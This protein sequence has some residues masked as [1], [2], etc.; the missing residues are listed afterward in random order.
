M[1]QKDVYILIIS[2]SATILI[3][4]L[5]LIILFILF[6]RRRETYLQQITQTRIEVQ[7]QTLKNISWEIHD[8]IGQILSTIS[9]YNHSLAHAA[10]EELK[11][12][13]KESQDLVEKA[14]VEVR[15]L[16]KA[17]NTD[18]IKNVGLLESIQMEMNRF[19]RFKFMKTELKI[20]GKPYRINEE[21][22]LILLRILQEFMSN[23]LKHSKADLLEIIFE[24]KPE[25]LK[26]T[27]KDN[28]IGFEQKEISGTGLINMK[29]RAKVIGAFLNFETQHKQGTLLNLSYHN[30]QTNWNEKK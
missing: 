2:A 27:A 24:Y 8:N 25:V 5:S 13:L 11:P 29:N 6:Q 21:S 3:F 20:I 16:S 12:K 17:L 4:C 7:E 30:K 23:S 14:I 1:G 9:I 26:I 28:G 15:A 18:Y 19:N 10:P 22:E